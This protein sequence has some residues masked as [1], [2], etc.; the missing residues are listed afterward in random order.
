MGPGVTPTKCLPE[1]VM[2]SGSLVRVV[3]A[4]FQILSAVQRQNKK[5]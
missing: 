5:A 4:Q 1:R 3:G 2:R